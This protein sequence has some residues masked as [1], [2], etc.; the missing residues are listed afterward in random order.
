MKLRRE[1]AQTITRRAAGTG[2]EFVMEADGRR[3]G[4]L[5][6]TEAD[7]GTVTIDYVEVA[8]AMRGGG[9]GR[10]LVAA[11]VEWAEAERKRVVPICSY[12]AWV[13]RRGER[14]SGR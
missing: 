5:S 8:P 7:S 12:A 4:T 14:S 11:A 2:G 3:Q 13:I 6:Y 1:M 10:Q 9:V